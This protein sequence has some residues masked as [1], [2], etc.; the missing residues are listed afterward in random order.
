MEP[1]RSRFPSLSRAHPRPAAGSCR[2][3]AA[4]DGASLAGGSPRLRERQRLAA[5]LVAERP[6]ALAHRG[7][8]TRRLCR[9]RAERGEVEGQGLEHLDP[10]VA[11]LPA[12][13]D[14]RM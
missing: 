12:L 7:H 3:S 13:L 8:L 2:A 14:P 6:H 5:D 11:L 1:A 9:A 10:A 4:P